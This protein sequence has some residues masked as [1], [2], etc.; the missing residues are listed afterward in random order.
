MDFLPS[1]HLRSILRTERFEFVASSFR[2]IRKE[3]AATLHKTQ[4]AAIIIQ[5]QTA[6]EL[7]GQLLS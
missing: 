5:F 6:E 4:T 7:H 1:Q 3:Q 2:R